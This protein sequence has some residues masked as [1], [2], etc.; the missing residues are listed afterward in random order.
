MQLSTLWMLLDF[1]VENGGTL[2]VSGSHRT[3]DNPT[4]SLGVDRFEPYRTEMQVTGT[5]GSV[6]LFDSRL[7]HATAANKSDSLR[8]AMVVRYAPWWLNLDI[9]MTG[10]EERKRI[11]E[12]PGRMKM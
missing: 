7:W 9:L 5:A 6:L 4:G 10:S 3:R 1:T 2:I 11:V 12:E 8:V